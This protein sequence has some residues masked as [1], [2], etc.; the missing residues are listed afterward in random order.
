MGPGT[1]S[2]RP[3]SPWAS[4]G[5]PLARVAQGLQLPTA[6]AG[7]TQRTPEL[8]KINPENS[9]ELGKFNPENAEFCAA[10]AGELMGGSGRH[11]VETWPSRRDL[12]VWSAGGG[13]R[14]TGAAVRAMSAQRA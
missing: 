2:D 11:S 12:T 14:D 3:K 7:V 5:P 8:E 13:V 4:Y 9:D 6:T 10:V 1:H